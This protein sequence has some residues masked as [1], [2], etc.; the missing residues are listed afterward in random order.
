MQALNDELSE[1][2]VRMLS[3]PKGLRAEA[4]SQLSLLDEK[5]QQIHAGKAQRK[6]A[7]GECDEKEEAT[8][9]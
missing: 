2:Q 9:L 5:I 3:T 1:A 6:K 4:K 8:A 7:A